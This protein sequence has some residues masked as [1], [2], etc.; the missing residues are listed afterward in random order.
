MR[1]GPVARFCGRL[2]LW[3]APGAFLIVDRME[4]PQFGRLE[5]RFHT[6][7]RVRALPGGALLSGT[8]ERLTLRWAADRPARLHQGLAVPTTPGAAPKVLRWC[9]EGL[10][11]DAAF[12]TLIAS[13]D[14]DT[15]VALDWQGARL[16]VSSRM[17]GKRTT[18][19][20]SRRL[21]P[22]GRS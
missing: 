8:K 11:Q 6:Y 10:H 7:G 4:L 20:L 5:A 15:E 14:A 22:A 18:V 2:F 21:L 16:A 3:L 13:G 1:D 9:T 17:G 19:T 12:A